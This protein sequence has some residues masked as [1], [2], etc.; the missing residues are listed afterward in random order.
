[1]K[2]KFFLSITFALLL[3]AL[4][5][6][7]LFALKCRSFVPE[8]TK[9]TATVDV[10]APIAV[11]NTITAKTEVWLPW[12]SKVAT[13][14]INAGKYAVASG[15][16]S[17]RTTSYG[18]FLKQDTVAV[19]LTAVEPGIT[20][21]ANFTF[22]IKTPGKASEKYICQIPKF[23]ISE[24]SGKSSPSLQLADKEI[25]PKEKVFWKYAIA[26]LSVLAAGA[27][28]LGAVYYFKIRRQ[29]RQLSEW[30]RQSATLNCC[31]AISNSSGSLRWADLSA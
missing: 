7:S 29:S 20:E 28:I 2:M 5:W 18:L 17:T 23:Q 4:A 26:I 24:P 8:I 10:N 22:T 6:G 11:G 13:E 31:A 16:A 1:M 14:E 15:A 3:A 19:K 27:V 12:F 9:N 21:D 30:E 25:A